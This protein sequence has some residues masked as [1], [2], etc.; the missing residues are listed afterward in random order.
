MLFFFPLKTTKYKK[1]GYPWVSKVFQLI[2]GHYPIDRFILLH[3]CSEARRI[4]RGYPL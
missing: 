3:V 2:A 4:E 1:V